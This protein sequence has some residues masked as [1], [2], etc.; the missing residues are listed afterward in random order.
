MSFIK[1]RLKRINLI[2]NG[3]IRL[4][5]MKLFHPIAGTQPV[6]EKYY[7]IVAQPV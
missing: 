7:D 5:R 2:V 3:R 1:K 6:D 4:K